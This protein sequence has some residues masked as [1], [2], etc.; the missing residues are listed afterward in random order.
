M[1]DLPDIQ[2]QRLNSKQE[3]NLRET[4]QTQA[5]VGKHGCVCTNAVHSTGGWPGHFIIRG[6]LLSSH[7]GVAVG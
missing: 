5:H 1:E 3:C 4:R 2:I 6:G 7:I